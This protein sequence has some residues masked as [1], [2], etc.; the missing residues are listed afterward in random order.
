MTVVF[1]INLETLFVE[2]SQ[3]FVAWKKLKN[4]FVAFVRTPTNGVYSVLRK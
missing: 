4:S 3:T 2:T 1:V